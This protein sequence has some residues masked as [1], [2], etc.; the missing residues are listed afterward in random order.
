MSVNIS[1]PKYVINEAGQLVLDRNADLTTMEIHR[2]GALDAVVTA[3]LQN[4]YDGNYIY[5]ITLT[6]KYSLYINGQLQGEHEDVL[7]PGEDI[8][9]QGM[10]DNVT[11]EYAAGVLRIKDAG[12]DSD[13]LQDAII[14]A[15]HFSNDCIPLAAI[16][17]GL[18]TPAKLNPDITIPRF[19]LAFSMDLSVTASGDFMGAGGESGEYPIGISGNLVSIHVW[20]GTTAQSITNGLPVSFG[21]DDRIRLNAVA[22]SALTVYKNGALIYNGP[23]VLSAASTKIICVFEM[24]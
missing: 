21:A 13:H 10:L 9:T 12:I 1:F 11:L 2:D 8:L 16:P 15:R 19:S 20:D 5:A 22:A 17:D 18:I 4:N 24:N 14:L 6:G 23:L 7:L 3:T